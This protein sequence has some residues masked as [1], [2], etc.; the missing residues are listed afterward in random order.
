MRFA[1]VRGYLK[2]ENHERDG[3]RMGK[4]VGRLRRRIFA[5]L[6]AAI[7]LLP[8][9][10]LKGRQGTPKEI[11]VLTIGT[12]D[13]GGTMYPVGRAVA[14]VLDQY[15]PSLKIN[16]SASSGSFTNV[17]SLRDG[18]IDMGLVSGD[19]AWRA[20]HGKDEFEDSPMPNLRVIGALYVSLS[21]WMVPESLDIEHVHD[22][23][24]MRVAVGPEDSATEVSARAALSAVGLSVDNTVLENQGLGS[25]GE[26]LLNGE[27]DALYGF[28]GIPVKGLSDLAEQTPCRLLRFTEEELDAIL[29]GNT[30]Y[31]RGVIPAGTYPGQTEDIETFG[32]KCLLCVNADM[33]DDLAGTIAQILWESADELKER[34]AALS[35]MSEE[36]FLYS[37]LP[38]PL[39]P[40]AAQFYR[41]Q[42]LLRG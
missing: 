21:N 12:A 32:V 13:S 26:A 35:A 8:G 17:E 2:K 14:E 38:V 9:C 4:N 23:L 18:Q 40:G 37:N 30:Q 25:G 20:W 39:H 27:L 34:H 11:R 16:T 33:D 22:L 5:G 41:D 1:L 10:G 42:G 6:L 24:G 3:E 28:A 7:C 29:Q 19:V 15:T 31:I 36:S